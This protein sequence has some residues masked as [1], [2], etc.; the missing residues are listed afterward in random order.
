MP[1]AGRIRL[2]DWYTPC[3]TWVDGLI[4]V[5]LADNAV[6]ERN[7]SITDIEMNT[8][9]DIWACLRHKADWRAALAHSPK[10]HLYYPDSAGEVP[11][12]ARTD[13]ERPSTGAC[14]HLKR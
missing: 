14:S 13:Y 8:E 2:Q 7:D 4:A 9:S 11:V 5:I 12:M 3:R 6:E 10:W 1:M